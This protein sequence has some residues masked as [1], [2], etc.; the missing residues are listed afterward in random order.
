MKKR[1]T[2]ITDDKQ[3]IRNVKELVASK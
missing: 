3:H 2:E 1:Q